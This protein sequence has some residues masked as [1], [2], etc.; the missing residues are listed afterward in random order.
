M[1]NQIPKL[2]ELVMGTSFFSVQNMCIYSVLYRLYIFIRKLIK[3]SA[4]LCFLHGIRTLVFLRAFSIQPSLLGPFLC[5]LHCYTQPSLLYTTFVFGNFCAAFIA[6]P[7]LFS[8]IVQA[9]LYQFFLFSL[10]QFFHCCTR[11]FNHPST[12]IPS[13]KA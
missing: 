12:F 8:A 10:L 1:N 3:F 6:T 5:S 9:S 4:Q 2:R 7:N 11:F 13:F